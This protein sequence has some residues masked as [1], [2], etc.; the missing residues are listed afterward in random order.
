MVICMIYA[1][2]DYDMLIKVN[3]MIVSLFTFMIRMFHFYDQEID[4][5]K[6]HIKYCYSCFL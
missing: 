3:L 5:D 4:S 1:I 6:Y 2:Y